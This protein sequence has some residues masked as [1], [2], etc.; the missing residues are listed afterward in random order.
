M[1]KNIHELCEF[2]ED[3]KKII[4]SVAAVLF[5]VQLMFAVQK[6]LSRPLMTSPGSRPLSTLERPVI[7][8]VCKNSQFDYDQVKNLK[9]KSQE[10]SMLT[11][12]FLR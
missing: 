12:F 5:M 11:E 1:H 9:I 4:Q 3:M 10:V 7:I 2:L 6:Y 8:T